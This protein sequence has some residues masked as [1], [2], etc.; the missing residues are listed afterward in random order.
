MSSGGVDCVSESVL[1]K[2]GGRLRLLGS[3]WLGM[4]LI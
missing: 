3:D 4:V 1:P 2:L